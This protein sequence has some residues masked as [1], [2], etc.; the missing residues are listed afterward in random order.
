MTLFLLFTITFYADDTAILLDTR[1]ESIQNETNA[2]RYNLF[3]NTKLTMAFSLLVRL[4]QLTF[5]Y[6]L[7]LQL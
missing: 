4:L 1:S 2:L 6:Y 3:S 7:Y 5:G